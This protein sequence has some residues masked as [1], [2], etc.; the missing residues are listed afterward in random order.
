MSS[1]G[2]ID[3]PGGRLAG[4]VAI[5]SGSSRGIGRAIA[6]CYAREG[7]G[8]VVTWHRNEAAADALVE[9]IE[10]RGGRACSLQLDVT[11]RASIRRCVRTAIDRFGSLDTVVNNA[12]F[13]EQK[14][15]ET[16]LDEDWDY[17]FDCNLK[18]AF[19]FAQEVREYF[20]ARGAGNLIQIASVGGQTGGTKAMHYA[21]AKAALISLTRSLAKVFAP[22]GV[23]VN[24]ISP[25]Y[26]QTDM[27]EDITTRESEE[28]I[29]ATI[30]LA[31]IGLP[32]DVATAALYLAS[33][34]ASY[35]TGHVLNVNG[36]VHL[37]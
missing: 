21:A 31:R 18:S 17:T 20:I 1:R 2:S 16:I 10:K 35:V 25:G 3:R 30:P 8:V 19:V 37:G 7:A 28:S 15:F 36:G 11:R 26:I 23:R 24:A 9:E 12:G 5:V 27:Y 14:P 6:E 22:H 32:D 33:E 29:L 4:K 34:D 13:L